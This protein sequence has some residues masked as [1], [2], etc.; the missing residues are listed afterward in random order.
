MNR[1]LVTLCI[2]SLLTLSVTTSSVAYESPRKYGIQLGGGF[3]IY[4][5]GDITLATDFLESRRSGSTVTTADAGPMGNLALIYRPSR[6]QMWEIGYNALLD[7]ENLVENSAGDSL[8]TGQVLMHANEFYAKA[9]IVTYPSERLN[10]N[11][12]LGLAYYNCEMQI[13]DEFTNN[14]YYDAVGRAFGLVGSVGLE[15]GVSKRVGLYLG[16]GGRLANVTNFTHEATRGVRSG[17]TVL[18]GSRPWEV[19][20]TGGYGQLGLRFYF[21]KVTEPIDFSR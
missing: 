3:G 5:M 18:N 7:V 8:T 11:F 14:Y 1:L 9:G 10:L 12:G 15:L 21:D 17:V 20:L 4:D 19:N 6:H 13:Q 2:A 16:G